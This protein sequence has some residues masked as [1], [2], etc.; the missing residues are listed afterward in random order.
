MQ[1]S[2]GPHREYL[3]PVTLLVHVNLLPSNGHCLQSHYLATGLHAT[4]LGQIAYRST[5]IFSFLKAALV[6]SVIGLTFPP[7]G[8]VLML[9]TLQ[10]LSLLPP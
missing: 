3:F 4:L 6:M 5:A 8:S 7:H 10:L 1:L 9:I 2:H